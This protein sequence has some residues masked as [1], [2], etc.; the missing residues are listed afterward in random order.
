MLK[1]GY[2]P[3]GACVEARDGKLEIARRCTTLGNIV[4]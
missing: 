1:L 2:S 3:C 4:E